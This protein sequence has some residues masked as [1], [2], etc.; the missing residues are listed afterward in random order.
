MTAQRTIT[1]AVH[2]SG[3]GLHTGGPVSCRMLPAPPDHG[4]SFSRVDAAQAP[5][6]PARLS[7]VVATDRGVVLGHTMRV[8]TV[9]HLLAAAHGLGID[10]LTVEVNGEELPCGDGSGLIFTDALMQAGPV[11]QDAPRHPIAVTAPV[12]AI[13]ER[14]LVVAI[15]APQLRVTVLTTVEGTSIPAQ[16]AEFDAGVDDFVATMASARTWG[17]AAELDALR[18]RALARGAS[19]DNVLGIGANGYLNEPRFSN[20]VAR[21]KVLDL[22]GDLALLGRPLHAHVVAI[23]SGHGLHIALARLIARSAVAAPV[24]RGSSS[25]CRE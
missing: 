23:R 21:H 4:V 24:T 13:R 18:T 1:R 5:T 20:E 6:I 2:L 7:E 15:P 3:I 9:E 22:I 25:A 12:W 17:F 14:S 11:E 19:L 10:N 8:A 16:V